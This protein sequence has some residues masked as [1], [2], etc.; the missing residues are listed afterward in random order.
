MENMSESALLGLVATFDHVLTFNSSNKSIS[1]VVPADLVVLS[2]G[3]TV[4]FTE[5]A[6]E[7]VLYN[8]LKCCIG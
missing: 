2:P 1:N 7:E 3:N 6:T 4:V 8:C 5:E